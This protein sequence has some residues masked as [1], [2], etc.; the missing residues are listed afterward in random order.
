MFERDN[1]QME[2][3]ESLKQIERLEQLNKSQINTQM[4]Q[5]DSQGLGHHR[6]SSTPQNLENSLQIPPKKE[7]LVMAK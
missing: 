4:D 2:L 1:L 7:G 6:R 5:S 3:T